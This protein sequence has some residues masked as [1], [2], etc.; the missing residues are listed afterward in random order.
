MGTFL[1]NCC[2]QIGQGLVITYVITLFSLRAGAVYRR[3][4]ARCVP[5]ELSLCGLLP[6][7]PSVSNKA[8][9]RLQKKAA[10][11]FVSSNAT[12]RSSSCGNKSRAIVRP[13]CGIRCEQ[14]SWKARVD[15]L[16]YALVGH[17]S[18]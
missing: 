5:E 18:C 9:A 14:H 6:K 10:C 16:C 11:N 8:A 12:T 4:H 7:S 1:V 17:R 15:L 13:F 2:L 3:T